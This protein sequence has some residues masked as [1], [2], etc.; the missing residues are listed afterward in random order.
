MVWLTTLGT[1]THERYCLIVGPRTI[2]SALNMFYLTKKFDLRAV[3]CYIYKESDIPHRDG[4]K[5]HHIWKRFYATFLDITD[6]K[7][8]AQ[9]MCDSLEFIQ[10]VS[11]DAG[12]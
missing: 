10:Q 5:D 3:S 2:V 12:T 8:R 1:V 6:G 11:K 4:V 9:R 7:I